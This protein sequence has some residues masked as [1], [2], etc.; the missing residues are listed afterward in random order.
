M[1]GDY[2]GTE[3]EMRKGSERYHGWMKDDGSAPEQSSIKETERGNSEKGSMEINGG[4][5]FAHWS[6]ASSV[7]GTDDPKPETLPAVIYPKRP[8]WH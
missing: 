7:M 5:L 4:P 2:N 3:R 1:G 8:P 6:A